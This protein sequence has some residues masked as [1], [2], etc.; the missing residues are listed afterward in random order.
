MLFL[1]CMG[2]G[3]ALLALFEASEQGMTLSELQSETRLSADATE[4]A[5]EDLNWE[6]VV[7]FS[8]TGEENTPPNDWKFA[9][10]D[11]ASSSVARATTI[12]RSKKQKQFSY[13]KKVLLTLYKHNRSFDSK[14]NDGHG[15]VLSEL[16]S[17]TQLP[18]QEVKKAIEGLNGLGLVD[19]MPLSMVD[20]KKNGWL[21]TLSSQAR[22]SLVI[23]DL[24]SSAPQ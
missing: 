5:L 3:K 18:T 11:Q 12:Y 1:M 20:V 8:P 14:F 24:Q 10:S 16:A 6:G 2:A 4:E 15:L 7:H 22:K 13:E 17:E 21:C 23:L 9:L 19:F